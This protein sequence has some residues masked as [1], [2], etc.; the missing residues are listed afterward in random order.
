MATGML[1][2]V[3]ARQ[4]RWGGSCV[5][6]VQD[7]ALALDGVNRGDYLVVDRGARPAEDGFVV[8]EGG[9]RGREAA[10][11]SGKAPAGVLMLRKLEH[12]GPRVRLMPG[13]SPFAT[14]YLPPES[15][16]IWGTV[17]AVMRKFEAA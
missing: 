17:V 5:L 14:P 12:Y 8:I 6:E 1:K 2:P 9:A 7:D 15:A 11:R 3:Q 16:G 13:S 10:E 4:G